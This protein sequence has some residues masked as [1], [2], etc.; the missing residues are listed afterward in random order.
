MLC[1][2]WLLKREVVIRASWNQQAFQTGVAEEKAAKKSTGVRLNLDQVSEAC[3]SEFFWRYLD[4]IANHVGDLGEEL[5]SWFSRCPCHC[6]LG[7][8]QAAVSRKLK[9]YMKD[10]LAEKEKRSGVLQCPM[11]GKRA[12]EVALGRHVA[13][14]RARRFHAKQA[15]LTTLDGVGVALVQRTST[16]S[17]L[18]SHRASTD[19]SQS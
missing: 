5:T 15:L 4:M 12:P 2:G 10:H 16:S 1:A 13:F 9:A 17:C 7:G 3:A 8:S 19:S 11:A 14:L 18:T 6:G